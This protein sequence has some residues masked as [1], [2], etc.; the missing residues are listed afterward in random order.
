[1]TTIELPDDRATENIIRGLV[2][3]YPEFSY[4]SH[5]GQ[6]GNTYVMLQMADD[7]L[8]Q[9]APGKFVSMV[10][11]VTSDPSSNNQT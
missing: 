7:E 8:N 4:T 1:M 11:E 3:A 5:I 9:E 10:E 6:D 2:E